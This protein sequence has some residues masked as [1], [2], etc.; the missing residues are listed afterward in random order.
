MLILLTANSLLAQERDTTYKYWMTVGVMPGR[1]GALNFNYSFSLGDYFYKAEYVKK[2]DTIMGGFGSDGFFF[3]LFDV[4][5]G[6]RFQSKWFQASL[7]AGPSYVYGEKYINT[8]RNE[9]FK[10]AGLQVDTQLLFR[11]ANEVG[12]G[13]GLFANLNIIK[14]FV[15]F[16]INITLGNGK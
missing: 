6:K 10:T 8:N 13:V 9:K 2:G 15:G 3:D 4:A 11:L 7:F 1:D 12:F 5:I 16:D 14:N